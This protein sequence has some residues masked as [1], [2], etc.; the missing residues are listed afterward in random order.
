MS[1]IF[2]R[3]E[4]FQTTLVLITE[5]ASSKF[6][7]RSTVPFDSELGFG[8]NVT[9]FSSA[10]SN[11]NNF[12]K[13]PFRG[14]RIGRCRTTDLNCCGPGFEWDKAAAASVRVVTGDGGGPEDS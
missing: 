4:T 12:K 14:W 8:A 6:A 13:L 5:P 7:A 2:V 1:C 11:I 3:S 9:N 10:A